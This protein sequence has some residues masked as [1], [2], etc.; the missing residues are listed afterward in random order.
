MWRSSL[1]YRIGN[2]TNDDDKARLKNSH[3]NN[4][5][6]LQK[7]VV[8]QGQLDERL[9]R[10]LDL[11]RHGRLTIRTSTAVQRQKRRGHHWGLA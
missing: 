3:W 10:A 2:G 1:D 9:F 11:L 4:V 6:S 7:A 5:S 8:T